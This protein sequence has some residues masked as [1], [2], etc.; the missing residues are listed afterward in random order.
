MKKFKA[1]F[2]EGLVFF[3]P[4][5]LTSWVCFRIFHLVYRYLSSM[6]RF[7]PGEYRRIPLLRIAV[8]SGI[9]L[10]ALLCIVL[11][12]I[13]AETM[14]GRY[15]RR[16]MGKLVRSIPLVNSLYDVLHQVTD[17][18]F[19]KSDE[20][21]SRPVIV[22]FP[23]PGKQAIGFVTGTAEPSL[24][25]HRDRE[26][27]KIFIPTVPIPTTGFF[28]VY[29]KELV[30]EC[31]LRTEEALRLVLSGGILNENGRTGA[32]APPAGGNGEGGGQ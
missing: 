24:R 3:V 5:V 13:F 18:L 22:P 31:G 20:L 17:I 16:K 4:A 26:Y 9:V 15:V 7:L 8:E 2:F 28:M 10:G 32:A 12:G 11:A 30:M 27:L 29:P 6:L 23:H 25:E 14:M 19:M 1:T 21:L